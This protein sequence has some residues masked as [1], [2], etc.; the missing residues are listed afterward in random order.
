MDYEEL[1]KKVVPSLGSFYP[2]GYK[3]SR[4][5][6]IP[7]DGVHLQGGVEEEKLGSIEWYQFD[8]LHA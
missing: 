3:W 5:T 2:G 8:L 7:W 1:N 6:S 4:I